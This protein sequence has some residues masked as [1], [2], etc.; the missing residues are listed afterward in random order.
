MVQLN[1]RTFLAGSGAVAGTALL[2]Q[3]GLATLATAAPYEGARE[4]LLYGPAARTAAVRGAAYLDGLVYIASR[5]PVGPGV[6]RLGVFDPFTGAEV[7]V[8]DLDLGARSGNN[9]MVADDR[10]VYIGPAGSAHVWR[11]D[12]ATA[13]V[14][15]FVEVGA[16]NTWTYS[17]RVHGDHLWIGTYPTCRLYRVHR[18]TGERTDFGRVGTSMYT[19][20]IAVDD[21]YVY[22]STAAPGAL[23]V[24]HHGGALVSDLTP[25][26]EPSP[27]GTLDLAVSGGTV[28]VSCG[29]FIISMK[30][31]GSERVS[32]PIAEEDRYVDKLAVTPDG[33]V[34][35]LARLTSN[36]WEVT[37]DGLEHLGRPWQ[38]VENAGFFP[39][40]DDTVVGVTG[41]G[42]V[43]SSPIGGD[44][45]VTSTALTGFGYP[46]VVQSMLAHS[47]GSVWAAG[48]FAITVHRPKD[49]NNGRGNQRQTG[50]TVPPVLI[51]IN[52]EPKSM[53]EAAD[54]TV[55]VGMYP[56]TQVIAIAPDTLEQRVLG[57]IDNEQM[58]PLAIAYDAV[59]GDVLVPT[60]G[61]HLIHTG[62][63]TFANPVTGAF[64]VRRDFLP[65]QNIRNVVV[66]GDFAYVAGDTFAE[67]SS[68]PG[69]RSVASIAEIDLRTR[70]VS[71]TFEPAAW[72]AYEDLAVRDGILFATGRN[73]R[74]AWLAFDLATEQV[75]ATGDIGGV[76]GLDAHLGRTWVWNGTHGRIQELSTA[77]GGTVVTHYG[78]I[79]GGFYNRAEPSSVGD[80]RGTWGMHGT[81]LAWF[82][83]PK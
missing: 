5:H 10:Y 49:R 29:R 19:T 82:P 80:A 11:F 83:L 20:G 36:Y 76:G 15:P 63:V 61:K 12:P 74:G 71:R 33:R 2:T 39:I 69:P 79:P 1:R 42:H 56:S 53:V 28:Y 67:A 73:P 4:P 54:G 8:H 37:P 62:A 48:H 68:S 57:T 26:L 72:A 55:V 3:Q 22:A 60:T 24:Y 23:K 32:R 27:V 40:T 47:D 34:L 6:V 81:D 50:S 66:V 77:D 43:W 51:E 14:E 35:A 38:D 59:R 9:Q 31:D 44:A 75:I 25:L 21:E 78:S 65:D 16:A 17:M 7:A 41:A 45:L 70:T 18:A 58:R 64:D 30:P 52:G 46:E 13:A